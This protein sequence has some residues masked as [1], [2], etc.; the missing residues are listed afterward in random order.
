MSGG[1]GVCYEGIEPGFILR[2]QH[3]RDFTGA[4]L[5]NGIIAS[6]PTEVKDRQKK[7]VKQ[8]YRQYISIGKKEIQKKKIQTKKY[9]K[10]NADKKIQ[11]K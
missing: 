7:K 6:C 2:N 3:V 11:E 10:K 9:R 4:V 1:G 8:K 5:R